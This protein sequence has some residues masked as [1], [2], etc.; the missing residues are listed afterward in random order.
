[1]LSCAS[2]SVFS[3]CVSPSISVGRDMLLERWSSKLPDVISSG[4]RLTTAAAAETVFA[5]A[6]KDY[7]V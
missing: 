5:V 7:I 4:T 2:S 6:I 3:S 1:M